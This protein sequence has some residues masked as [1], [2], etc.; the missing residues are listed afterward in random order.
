MSIQE[1]LLQ[2]ILATQKDVNSIKE[3][4]QFMRKHLFGN[5]NVG[6]DEQVRLNT[7]HRNKMGDLDKKVEL[8]TKFIEDMKKLFWAVLT[9]FLGQIA[10]IIVIWV[11]S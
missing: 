5:G 10:S 2:K 3:D 11:K 1:T 6:I 8:N 7:N 4:M 9:L